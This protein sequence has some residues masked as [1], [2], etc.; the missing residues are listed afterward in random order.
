MKSVIDFMHTT[1][2]EGRMEYFINDDKV[3]KLDFYKEIPQNIRIYSE[4]KE[5]KGYI[6]DYKLKKQAEY[7][8]DKQLSFINLQDCTCLPDETFM[9]EVVKIINNKLPSE[10]EGKKV[11]CIEIDCIVKS[12]NTVNDAV[13]KIEYKYTVVYYCH[14]QKNELRQYQVLDRDGKIVSIL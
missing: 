4:S 11:E 9:K 2:Q 12:K 14:K 1:K 10:F 5:V 7:S 3:I 6:F 8:Y 13:I